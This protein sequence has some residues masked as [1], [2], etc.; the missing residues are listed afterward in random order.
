L[1][2]ISF[3]WEKWFTFWNE[4]FGM[5]HYVL[6]LLYSWP[7]QIAAGHPVTSEPS[8]VGRWDLGP[9]GVWQL[10]SP[11]EYWGGV[12]NHGRVAAPD[13][14]QAKRRVSGVTGHVAA[15]EPSRTG[16][17]GPMPWDT[18]QSVDAHPASYLSLDL[19][20]GGTRS[21]GFRQKGMKK[22]CI[23]QIIHKSRY[24][25]I[26]FNENYSSNICICHVYVT[27]G[28]NLLPKKNVE[29][30]LSKAAIALNI[31]G[32]IR[33]ST[34]LQVSCPSKISLSSSLMI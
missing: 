8:R 20:R 15:P 21:A 31:F 25:I 7:R 13:P 27:Q 14:F 9:R 19:V 11:P 18:R 30:I 16:Q 2:K 17:P 3:L 4:N 34:L 5:W 6:I 1:E 29:H 28:V 12:R 33:N 22:L 10:R 23:G 32:S 24:Y 26:V